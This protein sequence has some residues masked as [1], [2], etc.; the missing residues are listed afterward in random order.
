LLGPVKGAGFT[1]TGAQAA[2]GVAL[3]ACPNAEM[4]IRDAAAKPTQCFFI[5]MSP[6]LYFLLGSY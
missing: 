1:G 5:P 2:N 3:W 6:F 4:Q